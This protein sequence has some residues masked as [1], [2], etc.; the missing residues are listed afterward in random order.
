VVLGFGFAGLLL[1]VWEK[2][3]AQALGPAPIFKLYNHYITFAR[4]TVT[5]FWVY[6]PSEGNELRKKAWV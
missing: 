2:K 4:V 5:W 3:K 6:L 1:L